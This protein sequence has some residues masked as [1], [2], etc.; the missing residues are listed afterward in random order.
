MNGVDLHRSDVKFHWEIACFKKRSNINGNI[1]GCAIVSVNLNVKVWAN[2]RGRILFVCMM[3]WR[4]C[5]EREKKWFRNFSAFSS[6]S[7]KCRTL[8]IKLKYFFF[9]WKYF[10][11]LFCITTANSAQ[12]KQITKVI[13]AISTH[14]GKNPLRNSI[15]RRN[16]RKIFF[17]C[18]VL[19]Y[20]ADFISCLCCFTETRR[21]KFPDDENWHLLNDSTHISQ[22]MSSSDRGELLLMGKVLRCVVLRRRLSMPV[23]IWLRI[24]L[25]RNVKFLAD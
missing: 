23:E 3:I 18:L 9:R 8:K 24:L 4:L 6:P 1:G 15:C 7:I 10:E 14:D 11:T 25:R 5:E 19:T 16:F 17:A 22:K 12:A 21:E 20:N 13:G 2:F